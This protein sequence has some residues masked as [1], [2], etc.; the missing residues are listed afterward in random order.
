[1]MYMLSIVTAGTKNT[2]LYLG[3]LYAMADLAVYGYMTNTKVKFIVVITVAETSVKDIEMRN[4]FRRIHNAYVNLASNPFWD[5]D[6]TA[7]IMSKR[8]HTAINDTV[9]K[10]MPPP[11]MASVVV[12]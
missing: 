9:G 8:F 2:D 4:V 10:P 7:R 5:P 1:M 12:S 3:L 6:G 11:P